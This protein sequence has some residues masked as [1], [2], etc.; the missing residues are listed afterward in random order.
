M[1][2][3]DKKTNSSAKSIED[4]FKKMKD[5][6]EHIL[7][8]PGM[9]IG[10]T[11]KET[12]DMWIYNEIRD[13]IDPELIYKSISYVPG[14][15]KIFDEI[16]VNARDHVIRCI[17]EK[18]EPCSVIKVTIDE[19]TGKISVWNNG[20][21]IPVVEH[22]EH[23]ILIPSMIFGELLTSG[24][25]DDEEKRKV[26]GTNGLGAK[27]TNIYST[28]FEVETL[29]SDTDKKFYQR[30]TNNMYDKEKPKITSGKGKKSYTKISFIPDFEKFGIK[31]L[32]E[33]IITLFKKRVYDIAM[34][35]GSRVKVFYNEKI[36]PVNSFTK[37]VDLYFPE[38]SEHKKVIDISDENWKVAVVYDPTDKL[39]HQNISF[40]NGICTYRG[41]THVDHV[42]NQIIKKIHA[43]II[44]KAKNL[45]IKPNM[46]K[47]NLI[48]FVDSVVINPEFDSQTKDLLKTKVADFGSTYSA[49]DVFLSKI[50][51]TGVIDQII[52]NAQARAQANLERTGKSKN[53]AQYPKLY[54]AHRA[55][56]K[57][58]DCAL[59]LTEGDS[60]K[61]F[62]LSGL[63]VI[64]RDRFGVF[65]LKGKLLNVRDASPTK[66]LENQEIQAIINIIGLEH[67]KV[68]TNT[69][70]L[71]YGSIIIL[72]DQDSVTGDTP[73]L[74][75]NNNNQIEIKT[76][77]DISNDWKFEPNGKEYGS[78]DFE[79]WTD[80]GWTKIKKVMRHKVNKNVHRVLTHSGIVDVT[81]DHSLLNSLG[82]EI[83]P[84]NCN[85]GDELMHHFPSFE[86]NRVNIPENLADLQVT[87]I[88]KYASLLKIQYYQ[89]IPKEELIEIIQN[90][91]INTNLD[92]NENIIN[93]EEAYLMGFFW[94]DG[95]CGIYNWSLTNTNM[96]YL[97]K[98]KKI[99]N[100]YYNYDISIVECDI[101]KS[102]N[103][104]SRLY[105]LIVNGGTEILPLIQKYRSMFY[106]KY[107]KK[108]I[109]KEILNASYEIRN[110]F[111]MGYYDGDGCKYHL[112]T[113]GSRYFDIDGKI[114]AHGMYFLCKSIGYD[115]SINHNINKPEVYTLT[116][117]KEHQQ[118]NPDII[119]EIF[120]LGKTEQY[121]YDL[122]TENHHFQ[123]GAGQL[124]V[125]NTDGSHIKGLIINFIHHFWP[126]LAK[127]EGFVKSFS[128]PLLKASKG[129]GKNIKVIEFY[130]MQEFDEWKKEN[131]DGKGWTIKYYKGL[132][133][134]TSKEAQDCF[135]DVGD[136]L[137]SYYWQTKM[138]EEVKSENTKKKSKNTNKYSFI[139]EESDL[140]SDTYK[141][142]SN[143]ISEDAITL[144]FAKKREDD[145]K[146]WLN[147]Y[148]SKIY[149]NNSE[150][151][152][153]YYDFIHKEL[154]AFSVY[155]AAR[156]L[157]NIMDG[158]K[159]GQRKIFSGC[160]KKNLY[161]NS[162][163]VAQLSGYISEQLQYHH[164]EDSLNKAIIKMA[165]NYVGSNNINLLVPDGQFGSRLSGGEDH[166]SPRYVFTRLEE[167]SKKIFIEHDSDIL[168]Q[169][170]DD[171]VKIEPVYYAPILPMILVNGVGGIGTGYSSTIEPC[172]PRD[173]VANI[174][175][176][177]AGQN[178]KVMKPWYRHF[179]GVIE[180]INNNKYIS[181]AKYDIVDSDTIHITDLPIG[182]WTDNYKE[183]LVSLLEQKSQQKK[184]IKQNSKV[185]PKT[186]A[187][188]KANTKAGSKRNTKGKA[189]SKNSIFL[190]KKSKNSKTAK[191]AKNNNIGQDIKSYKEDCTDIRIS[192]TIT[193]QPG[194][195][196]RHIKDGT[197]DKGLKLTTPLNLTNMHLFDEN[198][199]IKK[200]ES[201][202]A[203]LKNFVRVRLQ[204]YQ[205]RKDYLL[206]KWKKEMDILKWKLKFIERV[207]NEEIIV[208]K[209]KTSEIIE[210]LEEMEFPKFSGSQEEEKASYNYLTSMTIIKFSKDE[211][212]R[213]RKQIEEKKEEILTL[214]GKCAADIW[215]E[216]LEN[217]IDAYDKWEA[218][219]DASYDHLLIDKKGSANK[220]SSRKN[221]IEK[222]V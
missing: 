35:S 211:V 155:N 195:L 74:L 154:I 87:E 160:V 32:T 12:I 7:K 9:Y 14:L 183:F 78:T 4:R 79:I 218:N 125:H 48:F 185:N 114:G 95:T 93:P 188:S 177:I 101:S 1:S 6:H 120:N 29:D 157:P 135:E 221:A 167:I 173:I 23:K 198:G 215:N 39:E 73:L 71:R 24:N 152:V 172:N 197:L 179:T 19:E 130:S 30:F 67:K 138:E 208:F 107:E 122:E 65:P 201:Y 143:D 126:S 151:K 210:Q 16:L 70:G 189:N 108:C 110:N 217:F 207:I 144:A 119:K 43:C 55:K 41:G 100:K 131:N 194:K 40:V 166:A 123:A 51:K 174:K 113:T 28:E 163:K 192:I 193:F 103:T 80:S 200:Y 104:V 164:G 191:V 63:N 85:I 112:N 25:Y 190:A 124:I 57:Q 81:E 62:A 21:G 169:Q 206:D 83:A 52:L 11:K 50:I 165:Q 2:K 170:F 34:T 181:R 33:D 91:S 106:D 96:E 118:N 17:E 111:F 98:C 60:A 36:I 148:D 3:S 140:T 147:S 216:E 203:I 84:K 97:K 109:P 13:E 69:K 64:G 15:Y 184:Q 202:G 102:E 205:K 49:P 204:L 212:A 159:P 213:L 116:L 158:F 66:I 38:E 117:T 129:S 128:T 127:Y 53:L 75:K 187:G 105:K 94:V 18:R 149:I 142:K 26:G 22:K 8:R 58:G 121:V 222:E 88:W 82:E 145:R 178:P 5:Q 176:I 89:R 139:D 68:Y 220:R 199:K 45:V 136:K 27:L 137:I 175:R 219:S 134:S 90:V 31:N 92:L 180:K 182:T 186:K 150:K 133:T 168:D 47:E 196:S 20:A 37:Y 146:I 99:L 54:D 44:K 72:T 61:T 209:K 86:K 214:E 171:G 42:T 132:G 10:S 162:I 59:I 115:V 76:I 56:L 141:P 77:D 156:A 161:K 153:S 46:I